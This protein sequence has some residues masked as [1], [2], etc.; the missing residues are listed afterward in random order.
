MTSSGLRQGRTLVHGK[1]DGGPIDAVTVHLNS[2]VITGDR[3]LR[4][5]DGPWAVLELSHPIF[6]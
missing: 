6:E 4:I 3:G 2:R 1:S 5:R